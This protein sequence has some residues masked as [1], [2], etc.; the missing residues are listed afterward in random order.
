MSFLLFQSQKNV[1]LIR[2]DF[3]SFEKG[4]KFR[5]SIEYKQF[6]FTF[7]PIAIIQEFDIRLVKLNDAGRF[8]VLSLANNYGI[9]SLVNDQDS[10]IAEPIG[11]FLTVESNLKFLSKEF[12]PEARDYMLKEELFF[13]NHVYDSI[14][15]CIGIGEN[16]NGKIYKVDI[17]EKSKIEYFDSFNG[18]LKSLFWS[19]S[20]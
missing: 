15:W 19:V 12:F 16:N 6:W 8:E 7:D 17:W 11:N 13:F 3:D 18:F 5:I 1:E 4:L 9:L 20:T 2:K 10:S 14:Y